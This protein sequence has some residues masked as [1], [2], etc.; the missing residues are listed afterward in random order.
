MH[1]RGDDGVIRLHV[2]PV[3][4]RGKT[5]RNRFVGG[6]VFRPESFTD[7]PHPR[8]LRSTFGWSTHLAFP[9]WFEGGPIYASNR[10]TL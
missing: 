1:F 2:N 4:E 6:S 10:L 8:S 5:F 9:L 3:K 7:C